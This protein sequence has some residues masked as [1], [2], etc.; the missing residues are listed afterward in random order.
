LRWC[1]PRCDD[2]YHLAAV[3]HLKA[4][5]LIRLVHLP[6]VGLDPV[7]GEVTGSRYGSKGW[8]SLA[9]PTKFPQG[10]ILGCFG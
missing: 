4:I 7:A 6:V 1:V 8:V 9:I 3:K 2:T 10:S 5:I